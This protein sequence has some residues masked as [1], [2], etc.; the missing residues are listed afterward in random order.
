[1]CCVLCAFFPRN[2]QSQEIKDLSNT[3]PSLPKL[4][5]NVNPLGLLQFG[6]I[7][8]GEFRVTR[9]GYFT[10]H[11]RIPYLGVLYHVIN[12]MDDSE[13]VTLSPVALGVGV[14]YKSLFFPTP[15]GGWYLGGVVDYSFGSSEGYDGNAWESKFSHIAVMP[16]G[17][18][19]WRRP[20]KGRSIS[21]GAYAGI[22]T[23]VKD[24]WWYT[25]SGKTFDEGGYT[26]AMIMLELSFGWEK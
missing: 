9:R 25:S 2:V 11:I 19:R 1:M 26:T 15:K 18:Y 6:P 3:E 14:G 7:L 24:E 23:A 4:T 5:I 10:P 12:Q 20:E 13:E 22:Y 8:Q 21:V 17:G 16:N